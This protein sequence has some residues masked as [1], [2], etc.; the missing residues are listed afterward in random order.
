MVKSYVNSSLNVEMLD[1]LSQAAL[2]IE[3][4]PG[5]EDY[6]KQMGV[7]ERAVNPCV[8]LCLVEHLQHWSSRHLP[9]CNRIS[10]VCSDLMMIRKPVAL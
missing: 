9:P 7:G 6:R 4:A 3:A 1:I 5:S 8:T 2:L 10:K